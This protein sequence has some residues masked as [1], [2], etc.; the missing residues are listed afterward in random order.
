MPLKGRYLSLQICLQNCLYKHHAVSTLCKICENLK[1]WDWGSNTEVMHTCEDRVQLPW[2][3]NYF[4]LDSSNFVLSALL[5]MHC[6]Q[7]QEKC[8]P[9]QFELSVWLYIYCQTVNF[10]DSCA[11]TSY[12]NGW[13]NWS[14]EFAFITATVDYIT[15]NPNSLSFHAPTENGQFSVS[16]QDYDGTNYGRVTGWCSL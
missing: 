9:V 10:L 11:V 7:L 4:C 12:S 8:S 6:E 2:V 3:R 5:F 16:F 14:L 13:R 15:A 1:Y